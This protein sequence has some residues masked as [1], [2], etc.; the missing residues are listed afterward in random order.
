MAFCSKCGAKL[1]DGTKFCATC[2]AEQE[3]QEAVAP[4]E[5]IEDNGVPTAGKLPIK[6]DN[7]TIGMIAVGVIA[8]VAVILVIAIVSSIGGYKKP[9]KKVAKAFNKQSTDIEDYI[10]ALPE[11]VGD[12]YGDVYSI[13]KSIDKDVAKDFAEIIEEGM[14]DL[15]EELEDEL[16]EELGKDIKIS[17]EIKDKEK[18]DKGDCEDIEEAYASIIESFE[19]G[20]DFDITD[21]KEWEEFLEDFIEEYEDEIED[22]EIE[23]KHI[24]KA[25]KLVSNLAK[26]LADVKVSKGYVIEL[27]VEMAGKDDDISLDKALDLDDDIKIYVVKMNGKWCIEPLSIYALVEECEDFDEAVDEFIEM[28][29]KYIIHSILM[30]CDEDYAEEYY[31]ELWY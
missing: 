12:T 7:R 29:I 15:Y 8:L 18:L 25:I 23:S 16:K 2:G 13:I 24:E 19:D 22:M 26:D 4:V 1:E 20:L 30:E 17:Y 3:V 28:E 11:F 21:S 14:E 6:L 27:E 31:Y 10:D 9:F 5:T